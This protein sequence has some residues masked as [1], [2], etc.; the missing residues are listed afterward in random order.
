MKLQCSFI[1]GNYPD[2][3]RVIPQKHPYVLT[4]DRATLLTA[5]RRV[6]VFVDP[7]YGLEKFRITPERVMIKTDDTSM[8]TSAR[9][10]VACSFTGTELTIGFSAHHL[11]D[12]L[13]SM[14]T[15]EVYIDLADPGRP[16][17][18]RPGENEEDTDLLML[19][20]PMTVGEF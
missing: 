13:G 6:G 17:V 14:S 20:M 10:S 15:E 3:N 12:I 7:S 1:N 5:I 11:S 19:L 18:F 9:D 2:Y 16:G 4:A 8:C